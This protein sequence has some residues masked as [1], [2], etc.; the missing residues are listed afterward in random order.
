MY[1]ISTPTPSSLLSTPPCS[2]T[3]PPPPYSSLFSPS[4]P[5]YLSRQLHFSAPARSRA[6]YIR[7]GRRIGAIPNLPVLAKRADILSQIRGNQVLVVTGQTGCGKS[8]QV[9]FYIEF[10]PIEVFISHRTFS[11][12]MSYHSSQIPQFILEDHYEK[13]ARSPSPLYGEDTA[14]PKRSCRI[15]VAQPRRICAISL[16]RRVASEQ[17]ERLGQSIGYQIRLEKV[18]PTAPD[19]ILFCTTGVLLRRMQSDLT[20]QEFSHVVLDEVH[21]R[22]VDSDFLMLLLKDLIR[23][24]PDMRVVL[25]SAT[26][27]SDA[28]SSYFGGAP[29]FQ[30]CTLLLPF[31][32]ALSH[33]KTDI[34]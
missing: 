21:E 30:V 23:T 7:M 29:T 33:W 34:F 18:L 22:Q 28:F 10:I 11:F 3:T 15:V 14:F 4:F 19:S 8:T 9:C 20:L 31:C 6:Y 24:R 27:N 25:M 5:S 2:G 16:A 13:C 17:E 32:F 12:H 26:L 1:N